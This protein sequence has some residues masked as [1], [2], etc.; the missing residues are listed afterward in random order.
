MFLVCLVYCTSPSKP[1]V[2]HMKKQRESFL[3]A[4]YIQYMKSTQNKKSYFKLMEPSKHPAFIFKSPV[5][6]SCISN[7]CASERR[8]KKKNRGMMCQSDMHIFV[9]AHT[10]CT[11]LLSHLP[12][13]LP[14]SK[15]RITFD[16]NFCPYKEK[17]C[18]RDK[19]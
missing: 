2:K 9:S 15:H 19:T 7:L 10:L 12:V 18:C 11:C 17:T 13:K 3:F 5:Q 1:S 6:Y 8:P 16:T 4:A 14:H